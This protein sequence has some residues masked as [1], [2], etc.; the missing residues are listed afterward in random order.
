MCILPGLVSLLLQISIP[1]VLK[2]TTFGWTNFFERMSGVRIR[3]LPPPFESDSY[4]TLFRIISCCDS[5]HS[6]VHSKRD[7]QI[8]LI[9]PYVKACLCATVFISCL[10]QLSWPFS[11]AVYWHFLSLW[12]FFSLSCLPFSSRLNANYMNTFSAL[13]TSFIHSTIHGCTCSSRHQ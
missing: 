10:V 1:K 7:Y 12:T 9:N 5:K 8:W 13:F 2:H 11:H 4:S 3:C 6:P